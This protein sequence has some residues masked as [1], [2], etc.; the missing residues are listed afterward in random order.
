MAKT[1]RPKIGEDREQRVLIAPRI[2]VTQKKKLDWLVIELKLSAAEILGQWIESAFEERS[3]TI[4][5]TAS[6]SRAVQFVRLLADGKKPSA[7]DL[8]QLADEIEVD[9]EKLAAIVALVIQCCCEI[10]EKNNGKARS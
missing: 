1:G 9:S 4:K 10:E 5:L 3:A 7:L 2:T 8:Q 6:H